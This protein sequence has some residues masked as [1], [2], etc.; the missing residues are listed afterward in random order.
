VRCSQRLGR[1]ARLDQGCAARLVAAAAAKGE[2][3]PAPLHSAAEGEAKPQK[4]RQQAPNV[5]ERGEKTA[6]GRPKPDERTVADLVER[7]WFETEQAVVA[8]LT[9][10]KTGR[11]RY[12]FETAKPAADWLE[13]TLGRVPLKGGVLPAV[14]TVI[15]YPELLQQDAATL[16]RKWD[17]LVLVRSRYGYRGTLVLVLTSAIQHIVSILQSASLH[18]RAAWASHSR[19]SRRARP[20]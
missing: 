18:S 16:Q 15:R 10:S 2:P 20:F 6:D 14:M 4:R 3:E 9:R 8:L 17:A 7:G 12:P 13:A 1:R 5:G 19:S 11:S